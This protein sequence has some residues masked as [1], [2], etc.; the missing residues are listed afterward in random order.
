MKIKY[1]ELGEVVSVN[2]L[3]TGH[4]IGAPMQDALG[5]PEENSPYYE[6]LCTVT[7]CY[8]TCDDMQPTPINP[9]DLPEGTPY[10]AEGEPLY[11]VNYDGVSA[12]KVTTR[13]INGIYVKIS[14]I[15]P[16]AAELLGATIVSAWGD[17]S[18]EGVHTVVEV[19]DISEDG[20]AAVL[21]TDSGTLG[22][23]IY[24]PG[25]Y[26]T[27]DFPETGLYVRGEDGVSYV[28]TI[29]KKDTIIQPVDPRCIVLTSPNGKQFN[30]TV[31]N[32]GTLSAVEV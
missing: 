22:V 29:Y 3:T 13:F 9:E 32:D 10:T 14:D 26:I 21:N 19:T 31:A 25:F 5:T 2:G 18:I 20:G 12:G 4:H 17:G 30:L 7:K 8:N 16:T 24:K 15:T 6:E 28:Q 11:E 27:G 23:V 1:N